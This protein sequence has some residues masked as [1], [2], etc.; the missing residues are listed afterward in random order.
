ME[1][2]S[3]FHLDKIKINLAIDCAIKEGEDIH[4]YDWKTGKSLSENLSI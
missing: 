1:E 3:S 2:F 4:I